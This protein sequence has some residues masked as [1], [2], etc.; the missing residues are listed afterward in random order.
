MS[1]GNGLAEA[2]LGLDGIE[3]VA[4]DLAESFRAGLSPTSTMPAE[5]P[6]PFTWSAC[7]TRRRVFR[8]G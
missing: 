4:T 2:L 6:T 3:M 1:D 8:G 5:W 7:A